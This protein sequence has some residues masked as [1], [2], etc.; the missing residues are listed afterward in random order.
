M[1]YI[2]TSHAED[3]SVREG[4][5]MVSRE[6]IYCLDI[7]G[8]QGVLQIRGPSWVAPLRSGEAVCMMMKRGDRV[9]LV[10][11]PLASTEPLYIPCTYVLMWRA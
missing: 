5:I 1:I 7:L 3:I 6:G 9:R 10:H 8:Y 2:K 11:D 4:Y